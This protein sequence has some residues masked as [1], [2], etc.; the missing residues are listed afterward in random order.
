MLDETEEDGGV[1]A[2]E[3]MLNQLRITEEIHG[4]VKLLL[5]GTINKMKNKREA[6]YFILSWLSC[7]DCASDSSS[8]PHLHPLTPPPI[9]VSMYLMQKTPQSTPFS[10]VSMKVY[11]VDV[12]Y[13]QIGQNQGH[14]LIQQILPCLFW[15]VIL[16]QR[17]WL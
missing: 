13:L 8:R 12:V 1:I 10:V 11:F 17:Q 14:T 2:R 4:D 15:Y 5:D 3:Y 9:Y 16:K 7:L 6:R